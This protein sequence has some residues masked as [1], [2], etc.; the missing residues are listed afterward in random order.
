[1][2]YR[3]PAP[4]GRLLSLKSCKLSLP[5]TTS[6]RCAQNSKT[7]QIKCALSLNAHRSL[8]LPN[9]CFTQVSENT[10]SFRYHTSFSEWKTRSMA[11][12]ATG[13][14]K[15]SAPEDA[16]C[17][18]IAGTPAAS[19][20]V[21]LTLTSLVS[22]YRKQG[23]LSLRVERLGQLAR[24]SKGRNNGDGS[25]SLTLDE[26]EDLEYLP[27]PGIHEA[28][29][30]SIRIIGLDQDGSTLAVLDLPVAAKTSSAANDGLSDG[31][32]L[33]PLSAETSDLK[34]TLTAHGPDAMTRRKSSRTE[35][36]LLRQALDAELVAARDTW[37]I[38]LDRQLCAARAQWE[39]EARAALLLA[40]TAWN[41]AETARLTAAQASWQE[42]FIPALANI[43]QPRLDCLAADFECLQKKLMAAEAALLDRESALVET[44]A[45]AEQTL[46]SAQQEFE[47]VLSA[48]KIA[49][50]SADAERHAAA[51]T[52]GREETAQRLAELTERCA[53]AEASLANASAEL[54]SRRSAAALQ[55]EN[56]LDGPCGDRAELQ[57]PIDREAA[58]AR[59]APHETARRE[60]EAALRVVEERCRDLEFAR[61]AAASAQEQSAKGLIDLAARCEQAE[62]SLAD[63]RARL[64]QQGDNAAAKVVGDAE[65]CRLS[66]EVER[67]QADLVERDRVL[68]QT[69]AAA[70]HKCGQLQ[71][72]FGATLAKANTAWKADEAARLAIAQT[73]W[74]EHAARALGEATARFESAEAALAHTR[75]KTAH[76][77]AAD[78]EHLREERATLQ[79]ALGEREAELAVARRTIEARGHQARDTVFWPDHAPRREERSQERLRARNRRRF[80]CDVVAAALLVGAAVLFYPHILPLMPPSWQS[81]IAAATA[82]IAMHDSVVARPPLALPSPVL[83]QRT[84]NIIHAANLRAEASLT[85]APITTLQRG[86]QVVIIEQRGNWTF[87]RLDDAKH[88]Q[89]WVHSALLRTTGANRE[90]SATR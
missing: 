50:A 45:S 32:N 35:Q 34:T 63:A 53:L 49:W 56:M 27:P 87:V 21:A 3:L 2:R 28:H 36:Q 55:A 41:A 86:A 29:A 89:G 62:I 65:L 25:W 66:E 10:G 23:R 43:Q 15:R 24:L 84:A 7:D 64:K 76:D 38:E 44:R 26:L 8:R 40:E 69:N 71:D 33:R 13:Y 52:Q 39:T 88:R 77:N 12:R 67:L 11:L 16:Q 90:N 70:E 47:T 30:L 42:N 46:K 19:H 68:A 60:S 5:R 6:C 80:A 51:R 17:A 20:A 54:A 4:R 85:M 48:A 75:I 31:A 73:Q 79:A 37:N 59:P 18:P 83:R 14:A 57:D 9:D 22:P 81:N 82:T 78:K 72:E 74:R 61:S 58:V 1:M